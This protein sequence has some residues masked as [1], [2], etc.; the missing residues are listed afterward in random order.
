MAQSI[1]SETLPE[2]VETLQQ[3]LAGEM[4]AIYGRQQAPF[5]YLVI[6]FDTDLIHLEHLRALYQRIKP[7]GKFHLIAYS[8]LLN[9]ISS[10]SLQIVGFAYQMQLLWGQDVLADHVIGLSH[11]SDALEKGL[12]Q[13]LNQL[14]S[15]F[16]EA[17]VPLSVGPVLKNSWLRFEN[18]LLPGLMLISG[19]LTPPPPLWENLARA[20]SLPQEKIFQQL[21]AL[22]QTDTAESQNLWQLCL[23]WEEALKTL[24]FQSY[25]FAGHL[26]DKEV[27]L[28]QIAGLG[29]LLK[30]S[31]Q[32]LWPTE[33]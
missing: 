30:P 31:F 27:S 23:A 13:E 16:L 7:L 5:E 15:E 20:F 19:I 8:D 22:T 17:P 32:R 6:L 18:Q 25:K 33:E 12:N 29:A 10:Q 28:G 1:F 14:K 21:K 11:L 3:E 26:Q 2:V 4:V 24:I 9:Q